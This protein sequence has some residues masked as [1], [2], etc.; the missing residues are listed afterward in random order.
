M[1]TEEIDQK[2]RILSWMQFNLFYY[3]SSST[4]RGHS[5]AGSWESLWSK[6]FYGCAY[7]T[8]ENK[9]VQRQRS[10]KIR[11][12]VK[13]SSWLKSNWWVSKAEARCKTRLSRAL[14][15]QVWTLGFDTWQWKLI[16]Q[17][18]AMVALLRKGV[19]ILNINQEGKAT[20]KLYATGSCII[21]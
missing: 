14:A 21:A 7:K 1:G 2:I 18:K 3:L 8:K 10:S 17:T 11:I 15:L 13:D 6:L 5:W 20:G 12:E 9:K 19:P 16:K 4:A